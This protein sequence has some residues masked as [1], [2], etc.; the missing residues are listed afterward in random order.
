MDRTL[1][2]V[3][4]SAFS[5]P[6]RHQSTVLESQ[7]QL[8]NLTAMDVFHYDFSYSPVFVLLYF[9]NLNFSLFVNVKNLPRKIFTAYQLCTYLGYSGNDHQLK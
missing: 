5:E 1:V 7:F 2:S 9:Y 3:C 6:A 4:S 8:Q